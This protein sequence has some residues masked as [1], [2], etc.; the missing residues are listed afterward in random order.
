[1]SVSALWDVIKVKML[2]LLVYDTHSC[3]RVGVQVVDSVALEDRRFSPVSQRNVRG[4]IS[5]F[6]SSSSLLFC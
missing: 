5:P 3:A 4:Q 1:M 2:F 6:G